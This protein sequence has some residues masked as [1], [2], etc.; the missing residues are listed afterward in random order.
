MA[1]MGHGGYEGHH[2]HW[3]RLLNLTDEQ[4]AKIKDIHQRFYSETRGLRYDIMEK[5]IELKRLFLDPK[6]DT[7]AIMAKE[8]EKS[9]LQQK[10]HEA[11]FKMMV[12]WRGVLTPEQLQKLDMMSLAHHEGMGRMGMA[13]RMG[14]MHRGMGMMHGCMGMHD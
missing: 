4:K 6:A 3:A 14:M 7:N 13:G 5:R 1:M 12:E 8:G 2:G 11:V 9:A 10:L